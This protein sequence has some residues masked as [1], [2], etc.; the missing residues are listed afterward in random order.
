MAKNTI[1]MKRFKSNLTKISRLAKLGYNSITTVAKQIIATVTAIA[2]KISVV[3]ENAAWQGGNE[4]LPQDSFQSY[5]NQ[6][7]KAE[8][9]YL[10]KSLENLTNY[11]DEVIFDIFTISDALSHNAEQLGYV[12]AREIKQA[13]G[14]S[15]NDFFDSGKASGQSFGSGFKSSIETSMKEIGE[16]VNAAMQNINS[17][18]ASVASAA[19]SVSN[20]TY[21]SPTYNFYNSGQTVTEQLNEARRADTVNALRGV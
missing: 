1:S 12:I 13:F 7:S 3:S 16:I 15:V 11:K 4:S 21:Y 2:S 10:N 14:E 9:A 20:V 19:T 8:E 17:E 18:V 6:A 5:Y